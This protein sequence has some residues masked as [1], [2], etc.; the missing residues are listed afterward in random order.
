MESE[1]SSVVKKELLDKCRDLGIPLVGFAPVERWENPPEELPQHFSNWIPREFWPQPIYPEAETV[2]VIGLP[3]QLPIV[4]TAPSIYYHELYETVNILLDAKAYEISNFLTMKGYPSI[5]LPR[6]GYGDIEVLLEKPLAFFSHKHAAFLAGLGSFGLN[7]VLLTP[8][9]G[10]RV[11]FTSIFTTL[12]LEGTPISGDD[13]C[14]RCMSCAHNCPVNA[15]KSEYMAETGLKDKPEGESEYKT[16]KSEGGPDFPPII[17]KMT[18]ANR[19]KKLRKE[20]RSPCGICI[21]VCPVGGDREVFNR[22]ETSMYTRKEG[23]EEYHRAWKHVRR[24]GSKR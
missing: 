17:N 21:K 1:K 15:I 2:V 22:N 24:Y 20:Y 23:F 11:R 19:S 8:E 7:N 4:E 3:V 13:L 6:D 12:K 10:P 14:T 5:F 9:W 18:C 16:S